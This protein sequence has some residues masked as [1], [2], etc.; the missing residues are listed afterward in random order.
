MPL[1]GPKSGDILEFHSFP[2]V[3]YEVT[4]GDP[5]KVVW[6]SLRHLC[7]IGFSEN[8]LYYV[9]GI[10]NKAL[11]SSISHN[12]KLY[13]KHA[14][15]F[16]EA[17]KFCQSNTA[18]L[19]YYYS[20]LHLA[21][22]VCEI[23]N[24]NFHKKR[25][26]YRHGISWR[27]NPK[28]LVH[29]PNE[30]IYLSGRGIWQILYEA[31][32]NKQNLI[33]PHVKLKVKDL[34]SLCPE[35]SIEYE[36]IFGDKTPRIEII[37]PVLV[38]DQ[39]TNEAWI[40]FSIRRNELKKLNISRP[41]LINLIKSDYITYKEIKSNDSDLWTF[42]SD[43]PK[44][45]AHKLIDQLLETMQ[46]EIK[47]LNLFSVYDIDSLQ[48]YISVPKNIPLMLPQLLVLYSLIFWLGSLVR[49]D[50]HSLFEL[51][52]SEYWIL[53]DGF[54]NQSRIWLLELFEWEIYQAET[55]L[56]TR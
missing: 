17:G 49:Y 34:F 22:A 31:V 27:P 28:Y 40:R 53:I 51:Q 9:H 36:R 5:E 43:P 52:D 42:E 33:I 39:D 50:P 47:K 26:S 35:I 19:F 45:Y 14:F 18:P 44:Q 11:R 12:L 1:P 20:F 3:S 2:R 55:I 16:Y 21:K 25:E 6:S 41:K 29:M 46:P 38:S 15:D 37:E 4:I 48:Y 7:A 30:V 54:M 23:K 24:P 13:I 8:I 10:N 32:I 56:R